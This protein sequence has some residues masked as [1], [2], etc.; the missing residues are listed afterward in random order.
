MGRDQRHVSVRVPLVH[1]ALGIDTGIPA[2]V[3]PG[4]RTFSAAINWHTIA[5][6]Q[7]VAASVKVRVACR[8]SNATGCGQEV[9]ICQDA[10]HRR[11]ELFGIASWVRYRGAHG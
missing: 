6:R 11:G 8:G 2:R 5:R 10:L 1:H 3:L 7:S 4:A 9:D